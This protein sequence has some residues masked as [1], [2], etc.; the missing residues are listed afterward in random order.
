MESTMQTTASQPFS[1]AAI[2]SAAPTGYA[3]DIFTQEEIAALEK[4]QK[5]GKNFL[6]CIITGKERPAKPEEIVR[7]LYLN[8]LIYEYGYPKERIASVHPE[9]L[10][11]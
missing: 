7:Q 5:Q 10:T 11:A 2:L 4:V 8:K 1:I 6:K 9:T 3:L